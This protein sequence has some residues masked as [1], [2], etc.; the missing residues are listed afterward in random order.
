MTEFIVNSKVII[1]QNRQE[2]SVQFAK[3]LIGALENC[4]GYFHI[5]LSGGSTPKF[6][7]IHLA[8]NYK[9]AIDW[10]RIKIFW[11]DERCVPPDDDES[12]YKMSRETLISRID[13]PAENIFRIFGENNPDR[14]AFRYSEILERNVPQLND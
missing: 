9:S 5:A 1:S 8:E 11:V 3:I 13:I 14:E 4:G 2:L 10:K 6:I 12:N 7:N